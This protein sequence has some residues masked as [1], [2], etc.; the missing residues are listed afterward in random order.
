MTFW[1]LAAILVISAV[2]VVTARNPVHSVVGLLLNFLVLAILYMT[3]SAEFLS[4]IQIVVY[5]G[6]ILVLF[7]FVIALLSSGVGPF[8]AGPDRMP[9]ALVPAVGVALTGLVLL[10]YGLLRT[11]FAGGDAA[12]P[13]AAAFGAAGTAGVFG[14]IDDFGHALFNQHV[15]PFEITAFILM[16]AVIGVALLAGESLTERTSKTRREAI[17]HERSMSGLPNG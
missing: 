8:N 12:A 1:I 4:V 11:P 5:S 3:L 14:S 13:G 6:A 16:V 15:L 7:L 17:R 10:A 2:F 9:K